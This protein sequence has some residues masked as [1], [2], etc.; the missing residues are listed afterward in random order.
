M[1]TLKN[2][3][4]KSIVL[5]SL[6][7]LC[8]NQTYAQKSNEQV[9]SKE[10]P[11][12]NFSS[13][14][15]NNNYDVFI[16]DGET[17]LVIIEST[18]ETH[19]KTKAELLD[20]CMMIYSTA[21][22]KK[23]KIFNVFVTIKKL[24]DIYV[25]GKHLITFMPSI[26]NLNIHLEKNAEITLNTNSK[27]IEINVFGQGK[28]FLKGDY[29]LL[30]LNIYDEAKI[31]VDANVDNFLTNLEDESYLKANGVCDELVISVNGESAVEAQNLLTR[32]CTINAKDDSEAYVNVI[33]NL[34]INASDDT[35]IEFRGEP[36]ILNSFAN[37]INLIKVS[38]SKEASDMK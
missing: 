30:K 36:F 5:L 20:N 22:T 18:N 25:K 14:C 33:K 28:L 38:E 1:K 34:K 12:S 23:N 27:S 37:Y 3:L 24:N 8:L 11:T 10:F 17:P 7:T 6:W 26:N 13:L 21:K 35:Y 19:E 31:F 29:K 15:L 32:Y 4:I 2:G 16:V 9:F